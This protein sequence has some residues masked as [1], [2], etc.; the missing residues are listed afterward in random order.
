VAFRPPPASLIL[1]ESSVILAWMPESSAMDGNVP[2]AY[3]F[4]SG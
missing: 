4:E 2:I 1:A 3:A